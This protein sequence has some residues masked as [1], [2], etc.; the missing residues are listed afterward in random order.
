MPSV[1]DSMD[2]PPSSSPFLQLVQA[3]EA[4]MIESSTM[5]AATW[6]GS[7]TV[8]DYLKREAHLR[9]TDFIQNGGITYW[10]LVDV[11]AAPSA[12]GTRRILASCETYRKKALVAQPNSEV[13]DVVSHGIGSVFCPSEYRGRGFAQRML[14]ELAKVLDTWQQKDGKTADFTVLW[15]DIGKV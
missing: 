8:E 5:N 14:T 15:S 11:T 3:N 7:L 10:I 6:R 9:D 13:E 12:K 1:M 4:E 2:L